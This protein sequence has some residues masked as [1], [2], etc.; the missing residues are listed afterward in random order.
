MSAHVF[1]ASSYSIE[2]IVVNVKVELFV[3]LTCECTFCISS[4]CI[5]S[6]F[7]FSFCGQLLC[8]SV[9]CNLLLAFSCTFYFSNFIH[10]FISGTVLPREDKP[11]IL[12]GDNGT[13]HSKVINDDKVR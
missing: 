4:K 2:D 3:R 1:T 7:L 6:T 10:H 9:L 5:L 12:A 11:D 13:T 8:E